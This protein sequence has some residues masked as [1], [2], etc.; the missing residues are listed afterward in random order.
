MSIGNKTA[1]TYKEFLK[2]SGIETCAVQCCMQKTECNVAFVFNNKC[3]HVKCNDDEQCMP[4]ERTNMEFKL[5][6]V[7]VNPVAPDASWPELLKIKNLETQYKSMD[8]PIDPADLSVT[9]HIFPDHLSYNP[10]P[11]FMDKQLNDALDDRTYG[12][13]RFNDLSPYQQYDNDLAAEESK[14]SILRD[15][16]CA[17]NGKSC[18]ENES[19]MQI[20][21]PKSLLGV[22]RCNIGYIR[23]AYQKCVPEEP[24]LNYNPD[25]FNEKM[26]MIKH[27]T[28]NREDSIDDSKAESGEI[29]PKM[30]HLAV[31]VVSKT[32]QLPD[33]KATLSAFPVPDEQTSGATYNYSWSL[34]SQPSGDTNGTMS[35]KTKSEIELT[36]LSEGL[37]RFKVVVSGK[38]WKGETFANVT[39]L[40][41]KRFN[42]API[43]VIKPATQII[44]SPTSSAILDGSASTVSVAN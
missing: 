20:L 19:C 6:M 12:Y 43:V 3:F 9:E 15:A 38:N 30:G 39:V 21:D 40:P 11:N 32:V 18:G 33:N 2:A 7:L 29:D 13:P 23:N 41:E 8:L 22:C 5:K 42:K 10:Y 14:M 4:L 17:T 31:S 35:D 28:E 25:N 24:N 27:L 1:G 34:I 44:K 16:Q 36:N 37:Y 26:M